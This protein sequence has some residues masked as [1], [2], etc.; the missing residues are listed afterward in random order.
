M[1]TTDHQKTTPPAHQPAEEKERR[2]GGVVLED[3]TNRSKGWSG[4]EG[5]KVG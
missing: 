1:K 5:K 4:A 3:Q 2:G